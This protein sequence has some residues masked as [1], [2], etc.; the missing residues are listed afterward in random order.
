MDT[1]TGKIYDSYDEAIKAG[2]PEEFLITGTRRKLET[3]REQFIYQGK[4]IPH[5]SARERA[6]NLKRMEKVNA[7]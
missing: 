4:Y 2:V 1:R 5:S 3:I 6:R 7:R